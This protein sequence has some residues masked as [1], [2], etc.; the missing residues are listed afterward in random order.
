MTSPATMSGLMQ[1][2]AELQ[3]QLA[4]SEEKRI[5]AEASA[6]H[7]ISGVTTRVILADDMAVKFVKLQEENVRLRDELN[8]L[9]IAKDTR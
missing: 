5:A 1:Q 4:V 8:K 6:K 7:V 2:I 3:R 9:R